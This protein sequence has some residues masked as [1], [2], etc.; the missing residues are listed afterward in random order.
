MKAKHIKKLRKKILNSTDF[1]VA[2]TLSLFGGP[3]GVDYLGHKILAEN[4]REAVRKYCRK[5]ARFHK[6]KCPYNDCLSETTYNWG[7]LRVTNKKNGW[8]HYF[9]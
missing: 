7:T 4:P 6:Q 3:F 1:E 2:I 5:Y 8:K 9:R